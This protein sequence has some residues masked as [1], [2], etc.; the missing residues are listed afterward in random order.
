MARVRIKYTTEDG[1]ERI[2]SSL[3]SCSEEIGRSPSFISKC[4]NDC[5]NP[6]FQRIETESKPKP[7]KDPDAD[8]SIVIRTSHA[9]KRIFQ[10]AAEILGIE[11]PSEWFS[12]SMKIAA[13]SAVSLLEDDPSIG[14]DPDLLRDGIMDAWNRQTRIGNVPADTFD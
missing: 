9:R 2:F 7:V 4:V 13:L 1:N 8:T 3:K 6:R 12:Q 5:E 14:I 11:D 10:T